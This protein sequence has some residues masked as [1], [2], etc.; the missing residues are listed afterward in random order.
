MSK[1]LLLAGMIA[2]AMFGCAQRTHCPAYSHM[3]AKAVMNSQP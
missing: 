1:L 3:P 2:F